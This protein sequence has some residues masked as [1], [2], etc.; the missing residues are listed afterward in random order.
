MSEEKIVDKNG[1]KNSSL[2]AYIQV[3]FSDVE[4]AKQILFE[5]NISNKI[6]TTANA[7]FCESYADSKLRV[8]CD[9]ND[10]NIENAAKVGIMYREHIGSRLNENIED[11]IDFEEI[12]NFISKCF[13][14]KLVDENFKD[15]L[16]GA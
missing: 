3:N 14:R 4:K 11:F 13:A 9:A 5:N 16:K 7:V 6:F 15:K 10:T 12:D 8:L 1:L 2:C